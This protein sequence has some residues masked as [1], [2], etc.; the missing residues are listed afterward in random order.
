MLIDRGFD[1]FRM[2]L[3]AADVVLTRESG[4]GG[5][6]EFE[7]EIRQICHDRLAP[8][9]IPAT[10]RFVPALQLAAGGKLARHA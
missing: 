4:D 6:A 1:F 3:E 9:K 2:D 8:Y 5:T 7:R 10:I